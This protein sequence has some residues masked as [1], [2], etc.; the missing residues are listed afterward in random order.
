MDE[1]NKKNVLFIIVVIAL[2]LETGYLIYSNFIKK[3]SAPADNN[4]TQVDDKN[5]NKPNEIDNSN[6][7]LNNYKEVKIENL[8]SKLSKL[9]FN[10]KTISTSGV[11]DEV[12]FSINIVSNKEIKI[13]HNYANI[14]YNLYIENAISVGSGFSV[15]GNGSAVFYVLTADGSVYMIE[16]DMSKVKTTASY[17]GNA[18]NIG[19]KGATQIAVT[20][21]FSLDDDALAANPTVYIK[22]SDNKILTDE[23]LLDNE[24]IVSVV[25]K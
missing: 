11:S 17:V 23:N 14:S 20:D 22:T 7:N 10:S 19:V 3:D 25:E 18:V 5:N 6:K 8:N 24:N 1:N 12:P 2:V 15:Q 13:T 9:D 16:D 4:Q 21:D